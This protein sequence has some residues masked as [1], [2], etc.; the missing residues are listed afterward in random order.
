MKYVKL[1]EEFAGEKFQPLNQLIG[2]NFKK[3][4]PNLF[5][6]EKNVLI[7][8]DSIDRIE[9]LDEVKYG[10]MSSF[11]TLD[12]SLR[13][14]VV[15]TSNDVIGCILFKNYEPIAFTIT[16]SKPRSASAG[17]AGKEFLVNCD[18]EII[19]MSL[20][21]NTCNVKKL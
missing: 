19:K 18:D 16:N 12:N 9:T 15:T 10:F 6:S 8:C 21:N 4:A 20:I 5:R 13:C 3:V 14:G 7:H 11:T 17:V 2:Q 1:F